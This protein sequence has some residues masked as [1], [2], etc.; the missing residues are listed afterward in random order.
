MTHKPARPFLITKD[1]G[2]VFRL[3]LR[4]TKYNSQDYPFVVST[5]QKETFGSLAEA[6]SF[7]KKKYDAQPGEFAVE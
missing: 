1:E 6:K 3:T 7:A 4:D 2:G 5:L